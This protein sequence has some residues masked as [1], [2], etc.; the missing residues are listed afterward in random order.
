MGIFQQFPYSNFHEMNLDQII[1][2]MR[3]MQDEWE[4]TKT[5]WASYK[6]FIDN[7]FANLN[8]DAET[9]KALK[10]LLAAGELNDVIDPV[11]ASETAAWLTLHISQPT[12]PVVDTSLSIDGAAADSRTVGS[13]IKQVG[14]AL[15][16]APIYQAGS[17]E[18]YP[19]GLQSTTNIYFLIN[20]TAPVVIPKS[21]TIAYI[22]LLNPSTYT[23]NIC[24][25]FFARE[26]NNR[27]RLLQKISGLNM[28][29]NRP[30]P[31]NVS[32]LDEDVYIAIRNE[33]EYGI[34]YY[35]G[36]AAITTGVATIYSGAEP[37]VGEAITPNIG[38]YNRAYSVDVWAYLPAIRDKVITAG[39]NN[40]MFKH[41]DITPDIT[42]IANKGFAPNTFDA[43]RTVD[44]YQYVLTTSSVGDT[45]EPIQIRDETGT[46]INDITVNDTSLYP[47]AF[48]VAEFDKYGLF[49]RV[50]T[51]DDFVTNGFSNDAYYVV[52][53]KFNNYGTRYYINKI[54]VEWIDNENV[55]YTV[56]PAG[57]F[58]TFTQMLQALADDASPKTV[59][60]EE[61]EYDIYAEKG[62]A[63]YI[64]TITSPETMNWRDVSEVVPDNTK[65]IGKGRVVLKWNPPA[66]VIGSDAMAFLFSPLNVSGSCSIENIEV[67]GSNCRYAIHDET[68]SRPQWTYVER[69]YKNVKA[70]KQHGTYGNDQVYA[71]GIAP[72]GTYEFKNC[73][74]KDDRS[75]MFTIHT[76]TMNANDKVNVTFNDCVFIKTDES[77]YV[78]T[79]IMGFGNT[80]TSERYVDVALNNCWLNGNIH[81]YGE[82]GT[83]NTVNAF[84]VKAQG[85][86]AITIVSEDTSTKEIIQK[87]SFAN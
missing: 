40:F 81:T 2:I 67:E 53:R 19:S 26:E 8:L 76:T 60:V 72:N 51:A 12:T 29:G 9:E 59:Y 47:E 70:T 48:L 39:N 23:H 56:G 25:Y 16:V 31:I 32:R 63:A 33:T 46:L 57:D 6:D 27:Y 87:N 65:I 68:S 66:A 74:F 14:N 35:D 41:N 21:A 52:L 61:G 62:G 58:T 79:Y 15:N 77:G 17:A 43:T 37:A 30:L 86:N 4:N 7:Y 45:S 71:A 84:S 55:T 83:P 49:L 1:K 20:G 85:C 82:S 18:S 54:K 5:E 75:G 38:D 44:N 64:A 13:I 50:L 42:W 69:S 10:N 80:H 22:R 73:V 28:D 3:E 36:D 24:V 34:K 11:I 78:N